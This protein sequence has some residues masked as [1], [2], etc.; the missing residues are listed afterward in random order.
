MTTRTKTQKTGRATGRATKRTAGQATRQ[1]Q[2][3]AGW[4]IVLEGI[5]GAGKSTQARLLVQRL[6]QAKVPCLFSH[7]PGGTAGAEALRELL[8]HP[9]RGGWS[10][11]SEIFLF[12][13]ARNE[14]V[15]RKVLPALEQGKVVVLDRFSDSTLAYQGFGGEMTPRARAALAPI[16]AQAADGLRPDLTI[17]LDL[18]VSAA[19]RRIGMRGEKRTDFEKRGTAW[20]NRVRRGFLAMARHGGITARTRVFAARRY[21]VIDARLAPKEQS[22]QIWRAVRPIVSQRR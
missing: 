14:H 17:V 13:A 11:T 10:T 18:P 16:L 15:R 19:G 4:L 12:L 21:R 1:A 8:L 20:A 5:D 2:P 3:R 6:R 9:P 7:E 22:E